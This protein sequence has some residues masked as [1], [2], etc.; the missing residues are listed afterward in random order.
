MQRAIATTLSSLAGL[1]VGLGIPSGAIA[2]IGLDRQTLI[3][4]GNPFNPA[5]LESDVPLEP[6][7]VS[8]TT[9]SQTGLT[10]PSLW[11]VDQQF[12]G[13]L[14]TTWFAFPADADIPP[15]VDLVV[16]AQ[17]WSL[18]NYMERYGFVNHFGTA[19]AGYGYNTRVFD[20][21][22][23][24]LAAYICPDS[25]VVASR[26]MGRCRILLDGVGGRG[27]TGTE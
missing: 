2:S 26:A 25:D 4:L 24:L 17:V 9:I 8:A 13:Q 16:N 5:L 22:G 3:L 11:W 23:A 21:Q 6:G 12:G 15:R 19:G 18:F 10:L 14:L 1:I 7:V 27:L 20:R